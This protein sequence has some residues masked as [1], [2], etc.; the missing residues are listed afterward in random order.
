[1]TNPLTLVILSTNTA[2]ILFGVGR[3]ASITRMTYRSLKKCLIGSA[4]L[5]PGFATR[6]GFDLGIFTISNQESRNAEKRT[7]PWSIDGVWSGSIRVSP[8][9]D[10]LP[11]G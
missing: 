3:A 6:Y 5:I 1:M 4:T 9:V 8:I 11:N 10:P 2:P 7:L